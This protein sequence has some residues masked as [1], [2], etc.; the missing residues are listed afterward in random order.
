MDIYRRAYP[1][2]RRRADR[3]A[4]TDPR[5]VKAASDAQFYAAQATMYAMVFLAESM[6]QK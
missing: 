3:F 4:K 1:D 6:A 5:L 2:E